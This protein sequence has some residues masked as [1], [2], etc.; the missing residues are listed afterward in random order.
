MKVPV[1]LTFE[2]YLEADGGA[3]DECSLRIMADYFDQW[4]GKGN[5]ICS[6]VIDVRKVNP[7]PD[8][9]EE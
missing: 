5:W 6:S 2:V 9:T 8:P 4:A 3:A 1:I 7:F